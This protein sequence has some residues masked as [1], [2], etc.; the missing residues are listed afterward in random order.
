MA[1]EEFKYGSK[2]DAGNAY[3]KFYLA[4]TTGKWNL[5]SWESYNQSNY[6]LNLQNRLKL[7]ILR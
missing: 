4:V 2:E 1:A 3:G 7:N 5:E 6:C